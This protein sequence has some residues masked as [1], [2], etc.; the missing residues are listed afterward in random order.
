MASVSEWSSLL[1]KSPFIAVIIAL[2][3]T[4]VFLFRSRE[5]LQVKYTDD[6]VA[7]TK[8]LSDLTSEFLKQSF[9]DSAT[10]QERIGLIGDTLGKHVGEDSLALASINERLAS[11]LKELEIQARNQGSG[12]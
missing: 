10:W 7:A 12:R 11:I 1:E 9:S 2:G 6:L 3:I 8:A 4:C 5:K